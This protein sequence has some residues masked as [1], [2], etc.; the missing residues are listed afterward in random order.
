MRRR[1]AGKIGW[2]NLR[3]AYAQRTTPVSVFFGDEHR[4]DRMQAENLAGL[5]NV[6]LHPV[7]SKY[8]FVIDSLA[9]S[10]ELERIF[11][12]VAS[13]DYGTKPVSPRRTVGSLISSVK[14]RMGR[15]FS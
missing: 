10:G 12:D 3:E 6:E 2:P 15:I 1:A 9:T 14:R 5:P 11:A 13:W 7:P 4:V 8:H